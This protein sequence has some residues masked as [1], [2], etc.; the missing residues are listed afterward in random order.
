MTEFTVANSR[1]MY[2]FFPEEGED[3]PYLFECLADALRERDP[4][5]FIQPVD[6]SGDTILSTTPELWFGI[7]LAEDEGLDGFAGHAPIGVALKDATPSLAAEFACWLREKV[8]PA[9]AGLV[10]NTAWGLEEDVPSVEVPPGAWAEVERRME[11]HVVE[12][13]ELDEE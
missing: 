2:T 10:F 5:E 7:T 3:W 6:H 8:V 1:T 4:D 11:E 12:V 13:L 9:G